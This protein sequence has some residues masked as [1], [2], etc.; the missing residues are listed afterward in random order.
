MSK[1][2]YD[3]EKKFRPLTISHSLPISLA[4]PKP[5][6]RA[7]AFP[8]QYQQSEAS[9]VLFFARSLIIYAHIYQIAPLP[10]ILI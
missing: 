7:Q 3:Y 2:Q 5:K 10:V 1:S 6:R 9:P 4:I 8:R